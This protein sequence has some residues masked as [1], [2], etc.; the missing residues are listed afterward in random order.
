MIDGL[1]AITLGL[2]LLALCWIA[3]EALHSH[4]KIG[5]LHWVRFGRLRVYR[6]V[7]RQPQWIKDVLEGDR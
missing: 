5:G 7:G 6:L 2:T 1:I 3:L 4:R